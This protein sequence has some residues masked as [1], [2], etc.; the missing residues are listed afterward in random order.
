M[1]LLTNKNVDIWSSA[2]HVCLEQP[3]KYDQS[4]KTGMSNN[5]INTD[6]AF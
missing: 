1:D 3:I 6:S 4:Q 5:L 2:Y